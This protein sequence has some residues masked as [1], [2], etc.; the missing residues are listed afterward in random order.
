[1]SFH[2]AIPNNPE[3]NRRVLAYGPGHRGRGQRG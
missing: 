3:H 1:M 2:S